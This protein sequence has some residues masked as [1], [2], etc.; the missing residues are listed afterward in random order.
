MTWQ[1]ANQF[2]PFNRVPA[3]CS[4]CNLNLRITPGTEDGYEKAIITDIMIEFEG[5]VEF[6]ESCIREIAGKLGF[7]T[8]EA[9]KHIADEM[10]L[11]SVVEAEQKEIIEGQDSLIQSLTNQIARLGLTETESDAKPAHAKASA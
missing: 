4:N 6:C 2:S 10:I 5:T 1:I 9:Y 7:V 3:K 8:P 11:L